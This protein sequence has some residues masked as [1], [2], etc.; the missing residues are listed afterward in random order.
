[1]GWALSRDH[2]VQSSLRA[3]AYIRAAAIFKML[4]KKTIH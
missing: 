1:M 3:P 2:L 4:F